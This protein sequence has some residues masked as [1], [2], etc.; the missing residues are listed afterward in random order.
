MWEQCWP[1]HILI[2]K[3]SK[4]LRTI[5]YMQVFTEPSCTSYSF[6]DVSLC[7]TGFLYVIMLLPYG[8][9]KYNSSCIKLYAKHSL[10]SWR[11]Y[12][13][14]LDMSRSVVSGWPSYQNCILFTIAANRH[15][16]LTPSPCKYVGLKSII[17]LCFY[18]VVGYYFGSNSHSYQD[19]LF[20]I[21]ILHNSKVIELILCYT[22]AVL[23]ILQCWNF[24]FL[25][26]IPFYFFRPETF[27]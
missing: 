14:L 13:N 9:M 1:A 15:Y 10:I 24:R 21:L 11:S 12:C 19:L 27:Y 2:G 7:L 25:V 22:I 18:V 8:A 3:D 6:L 20:F 5:P 17:L 23:N 16:I 4:K 26:M